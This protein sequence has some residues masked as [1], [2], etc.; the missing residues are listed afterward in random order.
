MDTP[1]I[2]EADLARA[3]RECRLGE[4]FEAAMKTA[5]FAATIHALAKRN[6]RR[7]ARLEQLRATDKKLAQAN[8][9]S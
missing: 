9:N 8:D 6:V 7:A 5:L 1:A 3:W 4:S 2:S